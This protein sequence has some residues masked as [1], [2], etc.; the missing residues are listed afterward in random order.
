MKRRDTVLELQDAAKIRQAEK[1]AYLE[2]IKQASLAN[3]QTH[4]L[5]MEK[6]EKEKTKYWVKKGTESLIKGEYDTVLSEEEL[7]LL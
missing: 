4:K 1:V 7:Q 6:S 2:K 5:I 3:L